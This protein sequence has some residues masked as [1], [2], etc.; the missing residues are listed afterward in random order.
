VLFSGDGVF[1]S[2][3]EA[4]QRRGVRVTVVSSISTNP[5]MIAAELRRQADTFIDLRELRGKLGWDHF[6]R[7]TKHRSEYDRPTISLWWPGQS[8]GKTITCL[9]DHAAEAAVT[10]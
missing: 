6:E 5:L 7:R 3:V 1:R 8:G 2:L 9:H 4:L 10:Y